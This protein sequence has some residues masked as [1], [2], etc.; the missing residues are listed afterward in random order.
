M[1]EIGELLDVTPAE[2]L[3]TASFYTMF[4]RHHTGRY[5]VSV[6]TGISCMWRGADELF[7]HLSERLGVGN[8]QTT[9]DGLFT[10]ETA[11]CLA[12]CGGAPCLQVNYAYAENV[13]LDMADEML[14]EL[15]DGEEPWIVDDALPVASH[16][17]LPSFEE[18]G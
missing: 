17:G 15:R 12:A 6:C 2:V 3:G 9:G 16:P 8:H 18:A 4:K 10:L 1:K 5:L 11:E 14:E 13:S 7:A